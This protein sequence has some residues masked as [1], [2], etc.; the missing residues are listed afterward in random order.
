[1][2]DGQEHHANEH[3]DIDRGYLQY[4]KATR[5]GIT[6]R[7]FPADNPP[8]EFGGINIKYPL[9]KCYTTRS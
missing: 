2:S 5:P 3:G 6:G 4:N 8:D 7:T 9:G 1:M